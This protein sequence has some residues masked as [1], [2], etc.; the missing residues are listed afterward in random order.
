VAAKSGQLE[1]VNRLLEA[2]DDFSGRNWS[3]GPTALEEAA[4]GSHFE[5]VKRFLEVEKEMTSAESYFSIEALE[6]ATEH[7]HHEEMERLMK[8]RKTLETIRKMNDEALVAAGRQSDLRI[9]KALVEAGAD[10]NAVATPRFETAITAAAR[11]GHPDIVEYLIQRGA[12]VNAAKSKNKPLGAAADRGHLTIVE[13]L[14]QAG[15]KA[16]GQSLDGAAENGHLAVVRRILNVYGLVQDLK[17]IMPTTPALLMED[18]FTALIHAAKGGQLEIVQLLLD[19]R[20][21]MN[22]LPV[23]AGRLALTAA[24][25]KGSLEVVKVLL[26][27]GAEFNAQTG[28]YAH[29]H[30]A[31]PSAAKGGNLDVINLLLD[32][33]CNIEEEFSVIHHQHNP[34]LAVAA[35]N[36]RLDIVKRLL[37]K[38]GITNSVNT[39][40]ATAHCSRALYAATVNAQEDIVHYLLMIGTPVKV[41]FKSNYIGDLLSAAVTSGNI[42]IV[43]LLLEAKV[44]LEA[45]RLAGYRPLPLQVAVEAERIDLIELLLIAGSDVNAGK[46]RTQPSLH[47]ASQKGNFEVVRVL[48]N[49]GADV[50]VFNYEGK[51]AFQVAENCGNEEVLGLLKAKQEEMAMG[52]AANIEKTWEIIDER[53]GIKDGSLCSIC[54][55]KLPDIFIGPRALCNLWAWHP[56][57]TSLEL[58]VKAGC[59]FCIFFR[60]QLDSD[61]WTL[62]QPS[63]VRLYYQGSSEKDAYISAQI[64][65]PYPK[66]IEYARKLMASFYLNVEPFEGRHFQM[67]VTKVKG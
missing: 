30:S 4:G 32:S 2:D 31:L 58:S 24:A 39:T 47:I 20:A 6:T 25:E 5:V 54:E 26:S 35:G 51:T 13:K 1:V 62:P 38:M 22:F 56:S 16:D 49:A 41:N 52:V 21:D 29:H 33:G 36:G 65:E 27:A 43:K 3:L 67:C 10:L 50:D 64:T 17:C 8:N 28:P 42:N 60:K 61:D 7:G 59:P 15:A 12:D 40:L 44:D 55:D 14:I 18:E 53:E 46:G 57:L 19:S 66:D 48:L 23:K 9:V 63:P 34:A 45:E 37:Q 11:A